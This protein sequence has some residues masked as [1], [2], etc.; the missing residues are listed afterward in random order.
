VG[1]QCSSLADV[2]KG[3]VKHRNESNG[4]ARNESTITSATPLHGLP[5]GTFSPKPTKDMNSKTNCSEMDANSD[6]NVSLNGGEG[7]ASRNRRTSNSTTS[8]DSDHCPSATT[9]T[10]NAIPA[11]ILNHCPLDSCPLSSGRD[12]SS[13]EWCE[14][15]NQSKE[16]SST[17]ALMST[18]IVLNGINDSF[19]IN[20]D[21]FDENHSHSS[22]TPT[23]V[24]P[25]SPTGS[26]PHTNSMS[27][28]HSA[29]KSNTSPLF[30]TNSHECNGNDDQSTDETSSTADESCAQDSNHHHN[31]S[32]RV[33]TFAEIAKRS[34]KD[35][36]NQNS[37]RNTASTTAAAGVA[38]KD[39]DSISPNSSAIT[40]RPSTHLSLNSN[41]KFSQSYHWLHS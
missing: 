3:T 29:H 15:A 8:H 11:K 5:N 32:I 19:S 38:S 4:S 2:V 31:G 23:P 12:S 24:E 25:M 40:S 9:T 39:K 22:A 33:L 28:S 34:A 16:K 13:A 21:S 17:S 6:D 41:R 35:K 14:T 37:D 27:N 36:L 7:G 30:D 26:T 1:A 20:S 18:P 10:M